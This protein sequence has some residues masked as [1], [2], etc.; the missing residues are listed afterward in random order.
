[1]RGYVPAMLFLLKWSLGWGTNMSVV[2]A[3]SEEDAC[4][5]AKVDPT[6]WR[7]EVTRLDPEGPP[8]ILW[9][10]EDSPDTPRD[11]D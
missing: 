11:R 7:T 10:E 2:R 9:E 3:Q 4:D 8:A 6:S 5:M 1:M